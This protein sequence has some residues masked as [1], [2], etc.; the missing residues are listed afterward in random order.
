MP[1]RTQPTPP[2]CST[3]YLQFVAWTQD[4]LR[5]L[6]CGL[7]PV[8]LIDTPARSRQQINDDFV[9][10]EVCRVAVDRH[11][12]DAI[13]SGHLKVLEPPDERLLDGFGPV[14]LV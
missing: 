5:N 13:L 12:R 7:S 8:S 2:A 3:E 9:R 10:D 14:L 6:L 11:I 4:E 1:T